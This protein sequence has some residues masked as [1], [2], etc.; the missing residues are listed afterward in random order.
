MSLYILD[1]DHISLHQRGHRPLRNRLLT[2]SPELLAITIITAE[3]SVRGRLR[4]VRRAVRSDDRVKAYH[5]LS[6]T[7]DY[8]NSFRILRYDLHAETHFQAFRRQ[9]IR[10]GTQDSKIAA[11]ALSR[12]ATIVTRNRRDFEKVPELKIEDWSVS[13]DN[14]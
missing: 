5:W 3:E 9:K 2:V 14:W 7:L 11:I 6:E 8:L 13:E 4:Q 10:I 1:T 12:D